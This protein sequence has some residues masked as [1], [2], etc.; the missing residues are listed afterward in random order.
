[1]SR[2]AVSV[3]SGLLACGQ[4]TTKSRLPDLP[5]ARSVAEF[6]GHLEQLRVAL[7]IP[8][9]S[10]AMTSGGRI[11][12][13]RGF[14]E[15]NM[16]RR[17]PADSQT[18]YHLASLT[19]TFA[20]TV[21]LQLVDEGKVSLD[22]PVSKYGITL[23]S[24]GVIRV[25][26]LMSHTSEGVPGSHFRY[27]G[28]RFALLD[29]VI[30]HASGQTFAERLAQRVIEPLHLRRTAPN[31]R[32]PSSFAVMAFDRDTCMSRMARP[33][34]VSGTE[35][36]P[37]S[38]PGSF[39]AAAGLVSTAVDVAR[40]SIAMDSNA[41]LKPATKALAFAPTIGTGGDTLPYGLGWF[42]TRVS[43]VPV[44]WHYGYWTAN[45]SLIVKVPS[46]DLAFIIMANS[47]MLSRPTNLGGGDLMSSSVAREFI[48]A[49]VLGSAP[50][51]SN[52]GR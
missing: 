2:L 7:R 52:A 25:R 34:Q 31:P 27:N 24:P 44:V 38:Y 21:I 40:Y 51:P 47:D 43:G 46:R 29:S 11:V 17:V 39:S 48:N 19:K 8:A 13:A 20:S 18:E 32:S 5:P 9:F 42:S 14:G 3:A 26:H 1:M 4:P 28:N 35:N 12:W 23:A 10:A 50:L 41:F 30:V 15:A 22:D 6:E 49:F 37:V 45:S 36:A 16:E 33:Y